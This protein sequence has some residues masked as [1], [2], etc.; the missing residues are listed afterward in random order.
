MTT[1]QSNAFLYLAVRPGG[2]RKLGVRQ[3]GS[4]P[5][6]A[7]SLR[8]ENQLL[9][10]SWRVPGWVAHETNLTLK[11]QSAL[12]DQLAQLLSRGVPLV[13]ALDVVTQ[14]VVPKT[15]PRMVRLRDLVQSGSSF[16]DA[17]RSV[18]GFDTV[19]IAVY[20]AAERS[21]DLAGAA[22][23]LA[24]TARR[25]LAIAGK[26]TTLM[27]YP[28]IVMS[29][30]VVV[31][32]LM[33]LIVVP[34]MGEG[35]A[36]SDIPLPWFSKV[37]IGSGMWMRDN[38]LLLA[39]IVGALAVLALLG[40]SVI[41]KF[42][43]RLTRSLPR[44]REVILAQESARFFS[45]M[46]AMTRTGVPIAD[47]LGVANQAVSHPI[48]RRQLERLRNRLIEG[49]L[50]RTLIDE[51]STLPIATRRLLLAAE[52]SGDLENAFHT[53]AGDMADEV[54]RT[55]ARLL[56]VLEPLLIIVMFVLIGGLLMSL[57][58]PVITATS[59]MKL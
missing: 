30:S 54:E 19:Q 50:L 37:V 55:S 58:L 8:T 33:M 47:A 27:I 59:Q 48:M 4:L 15:R 26:A 13:E 56:A 35:L 11:D 36:K 41:M 6:L 53:L 38:V 45:V 20:R 32:T 22:K 3:A 7:Q 51:V 40:R 16:A 49:G 1:V 9:V 5:A 28:A 23:E 29:I 43:Q 12:N 42:L 25:R 14:T 57:M 52:R 21:G 2:G 34:M 17:C 10:K 44:I 39:M 18:G 24:M 46:G 31:A